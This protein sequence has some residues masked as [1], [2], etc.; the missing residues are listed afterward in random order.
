MNSTTNLTGISYIY[1]GTWTN[2]SHGRIA[3]ATLTLDQ[4]AAGY[5]TAFV[6]TFVTIVGARLWA[7][8]CYVSH[9][10]RS[11]QKPEDGLY[12]QQQAVFAMYTTPGGAAWA[13]LQQAWSWKGKVQSSVLRTVSWAIFALAYMILIGLA[14]VFSS[15]IS[16]SPGTERLIIGDCGE[17]N[18]QDS[19]DGELAAVSFYANNT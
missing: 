4:Q 16:K 6:A 19:T 7:I 3:G 9:Q 12:H 2:W 17:W 13:F 5:L 1:C 14:A 11:V 18:V 10:F 8:L 15:E